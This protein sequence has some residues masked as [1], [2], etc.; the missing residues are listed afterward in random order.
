MEPVK[1]KSNFEKYLSIFEKIIIP[2]AL[3]FIGY[4]QIM[5]NNLQ[6][7]RILEQSK[8]ELEVKYLELFY[9]DITNESN[10]AQAIDLLSV[11]NED[12][13]IKLITNM[14][15]SNEEIPDEIKDKIP[16]E[17]RI[18]ALKKSLNKYI[19]EIFYKE[20]PTIEKRV[21][22][23]MND[24]KKMG[25]HGTIKRTILTDNLKKRLYRGRKN[26]NSNE[27]RFDTENEKEIAIFLKKHLE[28]YENKKYYLVMI[29]KESNN[30]I[31]IFLI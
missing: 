26:I 17:L 27:I 7:K 18:K 6:E 9:Q 23:I 22:G 2:I 15:L 16:E 19:I 24:L 25:F 5:L 10:Q 13:A 21:S 31:S 4:Q 29:K 28:K 8:N 20:E 30:Y 11:M 1:S 3:V 14:V 12:L